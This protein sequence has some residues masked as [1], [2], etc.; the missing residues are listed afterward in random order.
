MTIE[1]SENQV[2]NLS[3]SDDTDDDMSISDKVRSVSQDIQEIQVNETNEIETLI[4]SETNLI[5]DLKDSDL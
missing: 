2:E 1:D 3:E 5:N 4:N